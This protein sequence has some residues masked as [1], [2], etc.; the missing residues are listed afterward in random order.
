LSGG[1]GRG[2]RRGGRRREGVASAREEKG[3]EGPRG[4]RVEIK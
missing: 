4:G 3:G 2:G 1:E